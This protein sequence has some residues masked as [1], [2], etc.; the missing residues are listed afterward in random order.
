MVRVPVLLTVV[1]RV[2]T[3][4]VVCDVDSNVKF[5]FILSSIPGSRQS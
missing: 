3:R 5:T 1:M 4:S 2:M